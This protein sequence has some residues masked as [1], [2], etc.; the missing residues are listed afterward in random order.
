MPSTNTVGF[1]V[2]KNT[3]FKILHWKSSPQCSKINF[4]T[5]DP[6]ALEMY[7]F[8]NYNEMNF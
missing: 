5:K 1:D 2:E 4:K 7:L 3:L 6:W 8:K